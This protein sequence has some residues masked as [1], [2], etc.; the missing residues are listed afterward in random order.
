MDQTMLSTANSTFL[1]AN[2]TSRSTNP[3]SA[4]T[5]TEPKSPSPSQVKKSH[6]QIPEIHTPSRPRRATVSTRSPEPSGQVS[7]IEGSP[8]KQKE[9]S[10]SYGNLFQMHIAPISLLEAE[11][12]KSV[13]LFFLFIFHILIWWVSFSAPPPE[14]TPRLSQVLD[15]NLFIAPL[16]TSRDD[17]LDSN[18]VCSEQTS[19]DDLTSSPFVVEPYPQRIRGSREPPIPDTPTR[20]RIEGVYDRFLMATSGVKRLGK[21]YQSDNAGP[22]CGIMAD[23]V[24]QNR[25][26]HF[27]LT[28]K[29]MPPPVSSEDQHRA[30]SMDE[31]GV[32]S[33][34]ENHSNV[35]NSKDD[36]NT[37]VA[38]VRKA[39]KL[40]VPKATGSRRLSRMGWFWVTKLI[41]YFSLFHVN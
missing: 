25:S 5:F 7:G 31:F 39:I 27:Y 6:L 10:R 23:P 26:R 4:E 34:D 28:R 13:L 36:S 12:S 38:L 11:L 9:R 14:P 16:L 15:R 40:I 19:L 30:A 1:S 21:G 3:P 22:V 8:S 32:I 35:A 41:Y 18:S 24:P 37:T 2:N 33:H 17:L 29:P 20:H